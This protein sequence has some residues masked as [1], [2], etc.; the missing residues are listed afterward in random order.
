MEKI[1]EF[2]EERK[3][4]SAYKSTPSNV[5]SSAVTVHKK[6]RSRPRHK[7]SIDRG[8]AQQKESLFSVSSGLETPFTN[9]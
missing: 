7:L 4:T 6:N 1:N 2:I 9:A 3:D 5:N 8:S